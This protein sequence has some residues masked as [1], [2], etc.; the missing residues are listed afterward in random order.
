MMGAHPGGLLGCSERRSKP[1]APGDTLPFSP[2]TS[3]E[4]SREGVPTLGFLIHGCWAGRKSSMFG[5]WVALAAPK[6]IPKGGGRR[7]PPS[8]MVL[9]AAEAAQTPKIGDSRPAQKP[10]IINPSV[11]W[12]SRAKVLLRW[13][14]RSSRSFKNGRTGPLQGRLAWRTARWAKSPGRIIK[15]PF[16]SFR[17]HGCHQTL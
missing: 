4:C 1:A 6:T 9:G 15:Q 12:L 8:G 17:G 5:V 14:V 2:L 11:M 13:S 3:G 16:A 10:R 7:P